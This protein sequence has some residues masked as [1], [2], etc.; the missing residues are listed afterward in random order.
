MIGSVAITV[1]AAETGCDATINRGPASATEAFLIGRTPE[2]VAELLPR[3]FNLCR[4]AQSTAAHLALGLPNPEAPETLHREVLRDHMLKLFVVWPELLRLRARP[5]PPTDQIA[6]AL[7]GPT[8]R[9]PARIDDFM[10]WQA[11]GTGTASLF[12]AIANSFAPGEAIADL[13]LVTP[14]SAMQQGAQENSPALRHPGH[15]LLDALR[16]NHG[17]GPLWRAV[18]RLVDAKACLDQTLAPPT[19]L[20]DGTVLTPAAR[21]I[22][23]V[24]ARVSA[25]RVAA[26]TRVTPT[27]HMLAP[28]GML[29]RSVSSLPPS[30]AELAPLV[31]DILDPCV[32]V[33]LTQI[34]VG[35]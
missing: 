21:G 7:F 5:F 17:P 1:R 35:R 27:D 18:A 3:L 24:R 15:L 14:Q 23:A 31:L 8:G 33:S 25:G 11:A 6:A 28:D 13:P 22:Y 10:S 9:L 12:R 19:I 16:A 34:M 4:S 26:F 32:P 20:A 29:A 30:K 2:E